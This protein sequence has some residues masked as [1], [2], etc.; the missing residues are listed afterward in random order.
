MLASTPVLANDE[1]AKSPISLLRH[2][3]IP[4]DWLT[5]VTVCPHK[6]LGV[7]VTYVRFKC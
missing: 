3:H 5:V 4:G 7:H 1:A 2:P 6:D